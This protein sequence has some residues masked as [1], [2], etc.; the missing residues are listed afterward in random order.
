MS[1]KSSKKQAWTSW[2]SRRGKDA[3]EELTTSQNKSATTRSGSKNTLL[4]SWNIAALATV[5]LPLF[6]FM[7]ARLVNRNGEQNEGNQGAEEEQRSWWDRLWWWGGNDDNVADDDG[8]RWWWYFWWWGTGALAFVYIWSLL[9]F[10]FLVWGGNQVLAAKKEGRTLVAVLVTFANLAFLC[11]IMV[12]NLE[13]RTCPHQ[14]LHLRCALTLQC[15][16]RRW[17]MKLT[18]LDAV[19]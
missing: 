6:M 9:F 1:E 5:L 2:F 19:G 16:D 17:N 15:F 7:I 12:G 3:A 4:I 11:C 14:D 13:V 10:G 8:P 18:R